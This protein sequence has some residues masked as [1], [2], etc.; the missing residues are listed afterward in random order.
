MRVEVNISSV[1]GKVLAGVLPDSMIE[2]VGSGDGPPNAPDVLLLDLDTL[3]REPSPCLYDGEV[4]IVVLA[5]VSDHK[6]KLE[7]PPLG[8]DCRAVH[9][10]QKPCSLS[11]LREI[12]QAAPAGGERIYRHPGVNL[13]YHLNLACASSISREREGPFLRKINALYPALNHETDGNLSACMAVLPLVVLFSLYKGL[14]HA[15]GEHGLIGVLSRLAGAANSCHNPSDDFQRSRFVSAAADFINAN[16]RKAFHA[17]HTDLKNLLKAANDSA[18]RAQIS[19][20]DE[21]H[22]EIESL[23]H[24]L[25]AKVRDALHDQNVLNYSEIFTDVNNVGERLDKLLQL[26]QKAI[27]E[28]MQCQELGSY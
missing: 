2:I 9:F 22:Q 28:H 15:Q 8:S 18:H 3:R 25:E 21:K 11:R 4:P 6:A 5:Y 17:A 12:I 20:F 1:L 26:R 14:A 10:V 19:E 16:E 13:Y 7:L 24:S 27:K 23:L